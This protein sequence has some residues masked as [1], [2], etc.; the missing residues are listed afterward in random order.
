MRDQWDS[1][2]PPKQF[3][4]CTGANGISSSIA[5]CLCHSVVFPI[6]LLFV[7]LSR[8]LFGGVGQALAKESR[9]SRELKRASSRG[10]ATVV[11][12]ELASKKMGNIQCFSILTSPMQ[13]SLVRRPDL[14]K[15]PAGLAH[16]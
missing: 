16:S 2:P 15:W 5:Y 7:G 12:W 14:S 9:E 1:I 10:L 6:T 3:L 13:E 8:C 4:G 11:V